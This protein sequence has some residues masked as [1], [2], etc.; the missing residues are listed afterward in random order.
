MSFFLLSLEY[1]TVFKSIV[2]YTASV[3]H[4]KSAILCI[5]LNCCLCR[6]FPVDNMSRFETEL[7]SH[8]YF[9][10]AQINHKHFKYTDVLGQLTLTCILHPRA[11][12]NTFLPITP[13]QSTKHL[14]SGPPIQ[15]HWK[16]GKEKAHEDL[17]LYQRVCPP[18]PAHT[19]QA[20][21]Y[22]RKS[23]RKHTP[24]GKKSET[25]F[26]EWENQ[27]ISLIF[28]WHWCLL[29]SQTHTPAHMHACKI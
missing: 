8:L 6:A 15:L 21:T 10:H 5:P 14:S 20:R 24:L 3:L 27:T 26:S 29:F 7:I 9:S 23:K 1:H 13:P 25:W 18:K 11:P 22:I 17:S 28:L 16:T 12:L 2:S 19:V 4:W